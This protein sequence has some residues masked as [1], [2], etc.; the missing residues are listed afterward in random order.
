MCFAYIPLYVLRERPMQPYKKCLILTV[1]GSMRQLVNVHVLSCDTTE[2]MPPNPKHHR[3]PSTHNLRNG[4]R[5][6][7]DPR[8][9]YNTDVGKPEIAKKDKGIYNAA[10]EECL[11]A[12]DAAE[13]AAV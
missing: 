10:E 12:R 11:E 3:Q 7:D 5:N 4:N 8:A 9:S 13:A 1:S 6:K 2:A